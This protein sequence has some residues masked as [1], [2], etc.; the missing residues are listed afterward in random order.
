VLAGGVWADR[1]ERRLVMLGADLSRMAVQ[2]TMAALL[3]SGHA[4]FWHL[5]V[6]QALYGVGQ[7]FFGPASTG[8][9]PQILESDELLHANGLMGATRHATGLLGTAIGGGLIALFGPGT[10]IGIDAAS[11]AVSAICL[12]SMHPKPAAIEE[13]EPF[14]TQLA[15]GLRE[16][17]RH[18]WLWMVILNASL[19]LMLYVAPLE[20]VGPLVAKQELGGAGVWGL[21]MAAF[22]LGAMMG[23]VGTAAFKPK[24]PIVLSAVLFCA[25]GLTPLLLAFSAPWPLVAV[26]IGIEG[27]A[28]GIFMAVYESEMQKKVPNEKLSR[29]SAWDWLGSLAGMPIGFALA[30]VLAETTGPDITLYVMAASGVLLS[31][32][33]LVE[34]DVRRIGAAQPA[35]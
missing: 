18:R 14:L 3:I 35:V 32:W 1:L 5:L 10:V 33:L 11:F 15:D 12:V 13:H 20:V 17:R 16:L 25:T 9:L 8:M 23:G 28:V 29:V 34:P 2:L 7:A 30:G 6:L 19:F 4:A 31:V 27:L 22:F 24:R 21:I 26:P